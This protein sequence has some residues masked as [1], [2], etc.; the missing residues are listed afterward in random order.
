M[1]RLT[2]WLRRIALA[3]LALSVAATPAVPAEPDGALGSVRPAREVLL[4]PQIEGVL[5]DVRVAEGQRV[6]AGEVLAV[7]DDAAQ[8]AHVEA[9][10]LR[11]SGTAA[12]DK[13]SVALAQAA[14]QLARTRSAHGQDAAQDW[15][16]DEAQAAHAVAEA[17]YRLTDQALA[18]AAA[19]LRAAEALLDRHALRAPFDAAVLRAHVDRGATV[20]RQDVVFE[21]ADLS[22]L[23]ADV[24]VPAAWL[25]HLR[26]GEPAAL[27]AGV[28]VGRPLAGTVAHVDP[29]IAA[30]SG[31]V[32]CVITIDNADLALPSG[33]EV[34]VSPPAGTDPA[35]ADPAV[36]SAE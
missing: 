31:R 22:A 28:P 33:F 34:R 15:E 13:A 23:E 12:R 32:R 9:A 4:R 29:R 26:I 3:P 14:G 11:A 17:E 5:A 24:F 25:G 7:V 1:T 6:S 21:L 16:L 27:A 36:A 2:P 10:R 18:L 20:G 35:G 8:R 30:G 19:E